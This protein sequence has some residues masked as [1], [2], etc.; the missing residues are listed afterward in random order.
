[1]SWSTPIIDRTYDDVLYAIAN[2]TATIDLKGAW[3]VSDANRLID[4][5][6]YLKLRLNDYQIY[7][8]ITPMSYFIQSELPYSST[9]ISTLKNNIINLVNSYYKMNHP[10]I[11]MGR[12]LDY[13]DANAMELNLKLTNDLFDSMVKLY[14]YSGTFNSGQSIVL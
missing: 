6:E 3:N 1:M 12:I 4:N 7:P 9:R 8:V 2:Q 5:I 13:T 14:K 10:V 11:R